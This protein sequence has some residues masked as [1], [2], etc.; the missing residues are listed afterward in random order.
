MPVSILTE[1]SVTTF[2]KHAYESSRPFIIASNS[3]RQTPAIKK[4]FLDRGDDSSW[5][6]PNYEYLSQF[7]TALVSLEVTLLQSIND[8]GRAP[9]NFYR[10][11]APLSL[12][13][14]WTR[15][16]QCHALERMYLAQA[17]T[18]NLPKALNDDLPVPEIVTQTGKGD[19]YGTNLWI[20]VPPTYTPLHRDPNPNLFVQL[21][22]EKVV[23]LMEPS[24]GQRLY[25]EVQTSLGRIGLAK[26]RGEE[27]MKGEEHNLLE[28]QVW[29]KSSD[30]HDQTG[31]EAHLHSGDG[32]FIPLGWWHSVRGIGAGITG[33]VSSEHSL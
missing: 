22:G 12:F 1:P 14:E 28:A 10:S 26:F 20:G 4:W 15:Q 19:I 2:R 16:S 13:L 32:L 31:Y 25:G 11:E 5:S 18:A 23:R 29:N 27:M 6:S 33:S 9:K 3:L 17:S 7:S 30:K 8:G 24:N 21:V